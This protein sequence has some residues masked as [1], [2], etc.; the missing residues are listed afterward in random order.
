MFSE[1]FL[2]PVAE[3]CTTNHSTFLLLFYLSTFS[4]ALAVYQSPHNART[5]FLLQQKVKAL[6]ASG[7]YLNPII[8][9]ILMAKFLIDAITRVDKVPGKYRANTDTKQQKMSRS[10][11]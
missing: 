4:L 2:F 7:I 1:G 3:S 11:T 8:R 5:S 9:A 10:M 6:S